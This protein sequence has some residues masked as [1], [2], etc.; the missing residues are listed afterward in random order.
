MLINGRI[1]AGAAMIKVQK[2][3]DGSYG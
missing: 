3:E 2:K 1:H